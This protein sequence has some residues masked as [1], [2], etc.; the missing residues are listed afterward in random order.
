MASPH[1]TCEASAPGK[2]ILFGEHAVV[3]GATA[4][5]GALSDLRI[6]ARVVS[7]AYWPRFDLGGPSGDCLYFAQLLIVLSYALL[8]CRKLMEALACA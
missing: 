3:H 8:S 7:D 5:A 6:F 2:L 4:V 1:F